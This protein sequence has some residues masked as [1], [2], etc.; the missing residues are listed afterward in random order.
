MTLSNNSNHKKKKTEWKISSDFKEYY[1]KNRKTINEVAFKIMRI[2]IKRKNNNN[3]ISCRCKLF[4]NIGKKLIYLQ[5]F[6]N[7]GT[8]SLRE[9]NEIIEKY[10]R[11]F[12]C[13]GW[14][15]LRWMLNTGFVKDRRALMRNTKLLNIVI[16]KI[17]I[18]N[19]LPQN[20]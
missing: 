14:T 8:S 20:F 9:F 5:I 12:L 15:T 18:I 6:L 11:A 16:N 2:E 17:K 13:N 7:F 3:L 10:C 19:N 1:F 4:R